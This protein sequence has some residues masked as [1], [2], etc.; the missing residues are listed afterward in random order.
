[1][2]PKRHITFKAITHSVVSWQQLQ[3]V[4]RKLIFW[5]SGVCQTFE[6][7]LFISGLKY[8][9]ESTLGQN[10]ELHFLSSSGFVM[11]PVTSNR[12]RPGIDALVSSLLKSLV[13]T[14]RFVASFMV[15]P[16]VSG[17]S[18]ACHSSVTKTRH[19]Q[20]T[21]ASFVP[22]HSF[23]HNHGL[24]HLDAMFRDLQGFCNGADKLHLEDLLGG[25]QGRKS[26]DQWGRV[27]RLKPLAE[28]TTKEV[29][30]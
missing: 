29:L 8:H 5:S 9:Q 25:F 24:T 13:R 10:E 4:D 3:R 15:R 21:A 19:Q 6:L 27:T 30:D 28:Q 7:N 18:T 1:M 14:P 11:F 12:R 22:P 2:L 23:S 16:G 26:S 20:P 17:P